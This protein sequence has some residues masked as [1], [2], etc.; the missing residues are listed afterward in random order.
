MLGSSEWREVAVLCC[1][2]GDVLCLQPWFDLCWPPVC[3]V[4][5][6]PCDGLEQHEVSEPILRIA[7]EARVA[8]GHGANKIK[9]C[10]L[11]SATL[12]GV[13]I[14]LTAQLCCNMLWG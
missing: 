9:Q 10:I 12:S 7:S 5:R 14:I 11:E 4:Q 8:S 1:H 2:T 3:V 13:F 6:R